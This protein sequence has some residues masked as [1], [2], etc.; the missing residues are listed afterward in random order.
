MENSKIFLEFILGIFGKILEIFFYKNLK[1]VE[2]WGQAYSQCFLKSRAQLCYFPKPIISFRT[3]TVSKAS[4]NTLPKPKAKPLHSFLPEFS[5][6]FSS[7]GPTFPHFETSFPQKLPYFSTKTTLL[8]H[9][10]RT[11]TSIPSSF[12]RSVG[13][14]KW[15]V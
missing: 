3:S 11:D 13:N 8:F 9:K 10:T 2:F 7:R 1:V 15:S 14:L 5:T 12:R 4:S 6:K